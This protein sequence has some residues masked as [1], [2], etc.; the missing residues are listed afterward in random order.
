ML[1]MSS[2][3][4]P[5]LPASAPMTDTEYVG[6]G[7]TRCPYCRS[8]E[9]EA[10]SSCDVDAGITTQLLVCHNCDGKWTDNYRLIGYRTESSRRN[11]H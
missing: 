5:K 7:G 11:R 6:F 1:F 4:P 8:T 2:G 9:I 10:P 3:K